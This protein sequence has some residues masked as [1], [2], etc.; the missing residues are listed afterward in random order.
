MSPRGAQRQIGWGGGGGGGEIA[1]S[2]TQYGA[3]IAELLLVAGDFI[4]RVIANDRSDETKQ[5]IRRGR[6]A[7]C[8]IKNEESEKEQ[9]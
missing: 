7:S 1:V 8:A 9:K 6:E 3:F 4:T 2:A 5:A